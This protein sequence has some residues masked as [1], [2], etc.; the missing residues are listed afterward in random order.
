MLWFNK[1]SAD[2]YQKRYEEYFDKYH[3][4]KRENEKL[5]RQINFLKECANKSTNNKDKEYEKARKYLLECLSFRNQYQTDLCIDITSLF[6]VFNI[7]FD[8]IM[9][10]F[11]NGKRIY[12]YISVDL[13]IESSK[14][15]VDIK[16]IDI[17]DCINYDLLKNVSENNLV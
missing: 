14:P 9:P 13:E 4:L 8:D 15:T 1:N 2:L 17:K 6:E 16:K 5:E 3:E 11:N 7:P 12:S 10:Q